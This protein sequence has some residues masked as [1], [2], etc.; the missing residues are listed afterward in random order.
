MIRFKTAEGWKRSP[1]VRSANGRIKPGSALIEGKPVKVDRYYYEVRYY[2][3]RQVQYENAGKNV[4]EAE[5]LR[6]RIENQSTAKAI[7]GSAGLKVEAQDTR[8]TLRGTADE[9][10]QD[11]LGRRATEAA[12][13]ARN[14]TVEFIKLIRKTY[15]DEVT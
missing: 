11:A 2:E 13:Q 10:F 4:S 5:T 8:K 12:A 15:V 14:V 7:A 1:A 6:Q 3:N 9:Y